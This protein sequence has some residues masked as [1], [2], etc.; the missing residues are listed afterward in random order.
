M[1]DIRGINVMVSDEQLEPISREQG[2]SF[3]TRSIVPVSTSSWS[4]IRCILNRGN[5]TCT[6]IQ[7]IWKKSIRAKRQK[8]KQCIPHDDGNHRYDVVEA[9]KARKHRLEQKLSLNAE[10]RVKALPFWVSATCRERVIFLF[11]LKN[12]GPTSQVDPI[13][14]PL[15]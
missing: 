10:L 12:H 13:A 9:R 1:L 2:Y 7:S 3:S 14:P 6:A 4:R 15:I 8:P 5:R 11:Y